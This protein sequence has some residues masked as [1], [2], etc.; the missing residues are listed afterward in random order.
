MTT[1]KN[2]IENIFNEEE[3]KMKLNK[4][5][6]VDTNKKKEIFDNL[7][8]IF[9]FLKIKIIIYIIFDFSIMLFFFYFTTAFCEVYKNTQI[10]WLLDSFVSAILSILFELF[11]S[12]FISFLYIYSIKFKKKYLYK[13]SIFLYEFE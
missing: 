9:K 10:S 3:K 4:D 13:I 7:V 12:F 1:S 5:Y 8:K 2:K 11:L 6:K